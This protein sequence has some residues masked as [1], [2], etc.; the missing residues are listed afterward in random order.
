MTPA[1]EQGGIKG[2]SQ[3]DRPREKLA[4]KGQSALSLAELLAILIGSGTR[5]KSAVALCR[6]ILSDHDD[7]L[8]KLASV[9]RDQLQTYKGV[10]PAKATTIL[11]ALELARRMRSASGGKMESITNSSEVYRHMHQYLAHLKHEEF[12]IILLNRA[13]KILATKQISRGGMSSTVA[14]PKVIF[15]AALQ[16]SATAV[17]LVHNH[18][19]GRA[20]PSEADKALT[21]KLSEAGKHM[22]ITVSDHII[23][24]DDS[25]F[26][27][28]DEGML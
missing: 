1:P 23:Y 4:L 9:T 25:Y 3:D 11:A 2:W 22:E 5:E 21:R 27:F 10:G 7:S 16:E 15:T 12:W 28:S 14:D 17:V 20:K 19:S 18:P 6:E 8:S 24:T 26:S 13:L